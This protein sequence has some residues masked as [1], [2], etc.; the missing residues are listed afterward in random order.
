MLKICKEWGHAATLPCALG[1][2]VGSQ[3]AT[4]KHEEAEVKSEIFESQVYESFS[5]GFVFFITDSSLWFS[6]SFS[7]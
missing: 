2:F 6:V 4:G 3:L 5:A 7:G 1:T